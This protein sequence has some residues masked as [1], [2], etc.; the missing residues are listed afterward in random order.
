MGGPRKE[1]VVLKR[2]SPLDITEKMIEETREKMIRDLDTLDRQ[3]REAALTPPPTHFDGF[4]HK[5]QPTAYI[6]SDRPK[7]KST[8]QLMLIINSRESIEE[9]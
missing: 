3:M 7:I 1:A 6:H 4:F 8:G 5:L 2:K 9:F